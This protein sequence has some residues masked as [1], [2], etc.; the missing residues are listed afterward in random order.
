MAINPTAAQLA[1]ARAAGARQA[2]A[3]LAARRAAL[4]EREAAIQRHF[5]AGAPRAAFTVPAPPDAAVRTALGT[6]ATA[7]VLLAEGDSWFD[8]PWTDVL[9]ELEDHHGYDVYSVARKGDRVEEMA[10]G[11]GQLVALTR[12]LEKLLR[13][14]NVPRALLL[15]GGGNDVAGQEFHVLLN[16]AASQAPGLNEAV[17]AG[18]I[19]NRLRLAYTHILSAVTALCQQQLGRPLPILLH[20]Y[21]YPVPDGRGFLGGWWALPGPWLAPGF[22]DKGYAR[23]AER[24]RHARALM[25]RFNTMLEEVAQAAGFGH[26]RYLNLRGTLSAAADYKRDWDNELHPTKAGFR[27]I[28]ERFALVLNE[29]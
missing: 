1:A 10:Y 19:D 25:D 22:R 13:A 12:Q 2:A 15:S 29:L 27:R 5:A 28:A 26:V 11:A 8:Y 4:S 23:L 21:D 16:H 20:G 6:A 24:K 7:G 9:Q 14:G 18:V 17:V 3:V